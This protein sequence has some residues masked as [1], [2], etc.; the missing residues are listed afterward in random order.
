MKS[1]REL[2]QDY[3]SLTE[4]ILALEDRRAALCGLRA[5]LAN[6]HQRLNHLGR[7]MAER[8]DDRQVGEEYRDVAREIQNLLYRKSESRGV[9]DEIANLHRMLMET[10]DQLGWG[11]SVPA[12]AEDQNGSGNAL[13]QLH[14]QMEDLRGV[15]G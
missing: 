2:E 13:D 14:R 12:E 9:I 1:H 10:G 6:L 3:L 4:Q 8:E 7:R 15:L 5:D 11:G